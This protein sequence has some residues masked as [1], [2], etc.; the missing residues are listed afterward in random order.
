M[1][2]RLRRVR[3]K[4]RVDDRPPEAAEAQFKRHDPDKPTPNDQDAEV[5][6][7]LSVGAGDRSTLVLGFTDPDKR[8]VFQHPEFVQQVRARLEVNLGAAK[9]REQE[10]AITLGLQRALLP[11]RLVEH[12]EVQIAARYEAGSDVLEVGGDWYDTF[13]L[14]DDRLGICVGDVVGH[15]PAAAAAMGRLRVALATLASHEARPGHVLASLDQVAAG[16]NGVPFATAAYA[17]L[18]PRTGE[19]SYASAGHPPMLLLA[20]D[21]R[22]EWLNEGRSI[23]LCGW[24]NEERPQATVHM[25]PGSLLVFYSDGLWPGSRA[26]C[27]SS[28]ASARSRCATP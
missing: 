27:A 25:A 22:T 2:R 7:P 18:E 11:D 15:G 20:P 19:L 17:I 14:G 28:P 21:G 26:R 1:T 5:T 24:P 16:P 6:L 4:L 10:R 23:P 3:S 13:R 8:K 9:L 12:R